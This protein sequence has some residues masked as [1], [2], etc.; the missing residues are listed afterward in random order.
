MNDS[1]RGDFYNCDPETQNI[2]TEDTAYSCIHYVQCFIIKKK[3]CVAKSK[4]FIVKI[5]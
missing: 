1:L 4:E 5:K 2:R 3:K